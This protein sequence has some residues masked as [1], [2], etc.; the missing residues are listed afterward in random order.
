MGCGVLGSRFA[1][2]WSLGSWRCRS[3]VVECGAEG[4][5]VWGLRV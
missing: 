4:T 1:R 5:E 3:R 2:L